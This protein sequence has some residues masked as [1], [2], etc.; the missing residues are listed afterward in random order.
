[1]NRLKNHAKELVCYFC[2]LFLFFSS[3]TPSLR[4][5]ETPD[6]SFRPVANELVRMENNN[7]GYLWGNSS[8]DVAHYATL[9]FYSGFSYMNMDFRSKIFPNFLRFPASDNDHF[10]LGRAYYLEGNYQL[11]INELGKIDAANYANEEVYLLLAM[12][13]QAL[14]NKYLNEAER[15]FIR[16]ANFES[17][18]PKAHVALGTFYYQQ[19]YYTD[20]IKDFNKVIQKEPA[21]QE[22]IR[23]LAISYFKA[24][25]LTQALRELHKAE[26]MD[27]NDIEILYTLGLVL[28][29]KHLYIEAETYF[30]R[31]INHAPKSAWAQKA[32]DHLQDIVLIGGVSTVDDLKDHALVQL[33][34]SAPGPEDFPESNLITLSDDIYYTLLPDDT[35]INRTHTLF[36]ILDERGKAASEITLPYD[37]SYQNITIDLARVINPDGTIIGARKENIQEV[38]P[39][40]E[41]PF[42][43]NSK[44]LIIS[45]PAVTVGSIIEYQVTIEDIPASRIFSPR[46]IDK[47]FVL[48]SPTP[49]KKAHFEVSIPEGREFSS[50]IINGEISSPEVTIYDGMKTLLWELN[51]IPA[52]ITEPM[53]PPL[54]DISPI[55]F[56]TSS[57]SWES[58]ADWWRDI[59]SHAMEPTD[60]IRSRVDHLTHNIANQRDAAKAL[61]HY[62]ATQI[63]YV[64]LEYGKGGLIPHQADKVYE[65]KY[66]D[67][68]D[69]T[70]LLVTML[71]EA[72]VEA[73]PVLISTLNNGRAWRRIPRINAFNH[74]ITLCRIND[75][76]IW[77]DPTVETS[78]FG[79]IHGGILDR[80]ALVI[81]DDGYEFV[82][83]PIP[84]AENNKEDEN[85]TIHVD[86]DPSAIIFSTIKTSGINAIYRRAFFKS[87]E[88]H[89]RESYLETIIK[90]RT[91]GGKLINFTLSDP[92]DV[93]NPHTVTL[94]YTSPDYIDWVDD[95]GFIKPSTLTANKSAITEAERRYPVFLANPSVGE[96]TVHITLPETV[97]VASLPS[98]IILEIPQIIFISEFTLKDSTIIYHLRYEKKELTIPPE[99]YPPYKEFQEQVDKELKKMIVVKKIYKRPLQ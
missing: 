66:G 55:L 14:G 78:S 10:S 37:S 2:V 93:T 74:V 53:A 86:D 13:Y 81:L 31:V 42:Y 29:E 6:E 32:E 44:L 73:Y 41:F 77:L 25:D 61:F 59:A 8:F 26:L 87:L 64:G 85:M 3:Y 69:K 95:E 20:A 58:I 1:M 12:A 9:L 18:S 45:M 84:L 35:L 80:E 38:S 21:N 60:A 17:V 88:P 72:G 65:N 19:G 63:R 79:D 23:L 76:W 99:D 70:I 89:Y 97:E 33:I 40:M 96:L 22:V 39:W 7:V 62:V 54:L 49:I 51:D 27:P 24:N 34:K 83:V 57:T 92:D 67:C 36:K 91:K 50:S 28:Y 94:T 5:S 4:S 90:E 15:Y 71:R 75:E 98:S 46:K 52:M 56:I 43:S 82:K 11:A 68:K 47:G 16:A 48:A 30:N